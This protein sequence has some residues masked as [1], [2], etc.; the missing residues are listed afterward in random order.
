MCLHALGIDL[1]ALG[2]V[3]DGQPD[4]APA[5]FVPPTEFRVLPLGEFRASDGRP[6]PQPWV[7]TA[8]RAA[9]IV[10]SVNARQSRTVIDWEHQALRAHLGQG[11]SAPAAGWFGAV[12]LRTE[13]DAPGIYLT[14]VEWTDTA[15]AKMASKEYRYVSPVFVDAPDTHEVQR[16][17]NVSL[18]NTPGLDGLTDLVA[19]SALF[20]ADGLPPFSLTALSMEDS[21][22]EDILEQ[23]RWMLNLP[24]S[25]TADEIAAELQKLIDQIKG[26]DSTVAMSQQ[27]SL[28]AW[29]GTRQEQ[30]NALTAQVGQLNTGAATPDPTKWAP[31]D[32]VNALRAELGTATAQLD[33][34]RTNALRA[35]VQILVD[36]AQAKGQITTPELKAY[37]LSRGMQDV[38]DLRQWLSLQ[39]PVVP[40]GTQTGGQRPAGAVDMQDPEAIRL[41]ALRY[42]TEQRAA[43]HEVTWAL[44]VEQVSRTRAV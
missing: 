43:G 19:L 3:A 9:A 39:P 42:Q 16:L 4:A 21:R 2:A 25:S 37:A 34:L 14:Q 12:E 30:I 6:G 15:V 35:E 38:A 11:P 7:L 40:G 18:T 23:L 28:A 20:S 8:E 10:A 17:L 31:V 22:M 24:L 5:E 26:A 36:E 44:A 1:V 27:F 13:G 41:A 29:I 33:T 32:T